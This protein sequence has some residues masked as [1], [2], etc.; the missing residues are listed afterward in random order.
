MPAYAEILE[1]EIS[2]RV[3]I[4]IALSLLFLIWTVCL[5][6]GWITTKDKKDKKI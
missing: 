3:G 4:M 1:S 6:T 5:L 2:F